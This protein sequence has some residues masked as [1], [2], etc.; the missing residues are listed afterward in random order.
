MCFMK[1]TIFTFKI[2][3]DYNNLNSICSEFQF[4]ESLTV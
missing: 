3:N 4:D 2:L 1:L